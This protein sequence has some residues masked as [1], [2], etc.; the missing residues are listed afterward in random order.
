MVE[1]LIP[2]NKEYINYIHILFTL[3]QLTSYSFT[4]T[5]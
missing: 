1:Q 2:I 3:Q 5:K 4:I